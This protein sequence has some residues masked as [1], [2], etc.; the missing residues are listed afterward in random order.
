MGRV[1]LI[2]ALR[3]DLQELPGRRSLISLRILQM[4]KK[5]IIITLKDEFDPDNQRFFRLLEDWRW[6]QLVE[7]MTDPD[8]KKTM[9]ELLGEILEG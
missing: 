2:C 6:G 9:S 1:D 5:E 8:N 4:S 7:S 3:R